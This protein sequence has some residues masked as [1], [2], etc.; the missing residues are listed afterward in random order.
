M[1]KREGIG[2][3]EAIEKAKSGAHCNKGNPLGLGRE[4]E[5]GVGVGLQWW[6]GL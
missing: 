1:G 2:G 6:R 4:P 3:R 5:N